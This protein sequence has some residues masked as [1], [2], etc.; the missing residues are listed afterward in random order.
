[1]FNDV[2]NKQSEWVLIFVHGAGG[3]AVGGWV[4]MRAGAFN[5]LSTASPARFL[6]GAEQADVQGK[7]AA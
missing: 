7:R 2:S 3:L 1:M 6:C 5:W 4:G